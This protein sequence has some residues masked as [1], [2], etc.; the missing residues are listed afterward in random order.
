MAVRYIPPKIFHHIYDPIPRKLQLFKMR[1]FVFSTLFFD[2]TQKNCTIHIYSALKQ[3]ILK[4]QSIVR[5]IQNTDAKHGRVFAPPIAA[6]K[7]DAYCAAPRAAKSGAASR[8]LAPPIAGAEQIKNYPS[9]DQKNSIPLSYKKLLNAQQ[10]R[11]SF[12]F[13]FRKQHL[14][15]LYGSP[16][17]RFDP[18]FHGN[19]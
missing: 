10:D 2:Q 7:C 19:L 3:I 13:M 16:A 5:V 1:N 6:T 17:C 14:F 4:F 9:L 15:G 11:F 8:V 12:V 18:Y